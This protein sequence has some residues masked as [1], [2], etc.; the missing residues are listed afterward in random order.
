M[1]LY[2]FYPFTFFY[3]IFKPAS[4]KPKFFLKNSKK[5]GGAFT[6][7]RKPTLPALP[8]HRSIR[9]AMVLL[10]GRDKSR[11]GDGTL[12]AVLLQRLL[13]NQQAIRIHVQALFAWENDHIHVVHR[14]W[15]SKGSVV[16]GD[17]TARVVVLRFL[18]RISTGPT[19]SNFWSVPSASSKICSSSF[20]SPS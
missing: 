11:T 10:R 3:F 6:P 5:A 14:V 1:T 9:H 7:A 17:S 2:F 4:A 16:P 18:K 13:R 20:S 8:A 15:P 19:T 12:A